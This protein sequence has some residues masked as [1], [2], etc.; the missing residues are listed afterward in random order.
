VIQ[1]ISGARIKIARADEHINQ[2]KNADREFFDSYPPPFE[3]VEEDDPKTGDLVFIAKV[4]REPQMRLGAIFA[5]AAHNLRC[6]LDFLY[7]AI[8]HPAGAPISNR[9]NNFRW[10]DDA[11]HLRKACEGL[12]KSAPAP[13]VDVL[14]AL[15]PYPGGNDSLKRLIDTDDS[16][17]HFGVVPSIAAARN[18]TAKYI[19]IEVD[20]ITGQDLLIP[21]I[22]RLISG[23]PAAIP[24][25]EGAV[26]HRIP[27]AD[28]P[29][30]KV[31]MHPQPARCIV[32]TQPGVFEREGIELLF[33]WRRRV[34][35]FT[36]DLQTAMLDL[37]PGTRGAPT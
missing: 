10:F 16:N 26:F 27:A 21:V 31:D 8:L 33:G 36:N 4:V 13:L 29:T 2:L 6:A 25:Y 23:G 18:S 15:K 11:E 20:P 32:F 9:G 35:T 22:E 30:T 37:K 14:H 19:K 24:I 28:R 12:K 5:D 1:G 7:L 17:K 3:L 34:L